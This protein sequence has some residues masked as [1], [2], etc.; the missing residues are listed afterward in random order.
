[1]SEYGVTKKGFVP[2]RLDVILEE[3]HSDLSDGFGFN[4]RQNPQSYLNVLMTAFADKVAELWEVAEDNYHSMYPSSAEDISLD[5][6]A[7]FGGSTREVAAKTYY[8]LHCTGLDGTVLA[9]GTAVASKTN[10]AINFSASEDSIIT[11]EA[12]NKVAVSVASVAD[13]RGYSVALNNQLYT[14]TSGTDATALD[15]LRG[16]AEAID[17]D[18][19]QATV[20]EANGAV[21]IEA[22]DIQSSNSLVLT[23][24]LTTASVTSILNFASE[25][26][27]E[28]VLPDRTITVIVRSVPGFLS[29]TNL[30]GYIAGRFREKDVEFRKSYANKIFNRSSRMLASIESAILSNVQGIQSVKAYENDTNVVDADGRWPHSIEV[31]VE[32]G[33]NT[34]IASQILNVKAGG[35]NTFGGI[36]VE[37]PGEEGENITVR[38]NRPEYVYCWFKVNITIS[39]SQSLPANY[40]ELV[41][42]VVSDRVT[43]L[44]SGEDVTPQRYIAGIYAAVPGIDYIEILVHANTDGNATPPPTFTDRSVAI[45]ARQLA[46]TSNQRIEVTL[47]E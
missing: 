47:N 18:N 7:Q 9:Q 38:F 31:V 35:I 15:I 22:N 20:D 16:L 29:C 33:S 40:A 14:Y 36:E 25:E 8:P 23:E 30:C 5:N 21:K 10:P 32:G 44:T 28:V 39:Q 12:F 42:E 6:A 13:D 2:K 19:F 37:I 46:V 24:N 1:M 26:Y 34:E 43:A 45:S 41:K 17:D 4:T 3:L 27:G 11:R